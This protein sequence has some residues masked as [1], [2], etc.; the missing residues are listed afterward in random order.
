MA[1]PPGR[2]TRARPN[3]A[4]SGPS[5]NTEARIVLTSS[6]GA[7]G[8]G[9][10]DAS[11]S[12]VCPPRSA[13]RVIFAPMCK[14][15]RPIVRMSARSGTSRKTL[16][17][18][19]SRAAASCGSVAFFDP[20][21]ST[22]PFSGTPPSISIASIRKGPRRSSI[23]RFR[24]PAEN[25]AIE[26]GQVLDDADVREPRLCT[27]VPHGTGK[28][29]VDLDAEESTGD[30][31]ASRLG[32]DSPDHRQPSLRGE[33]RLGRLVHDDFGREAIS[34][35]FGNIRRI[36]DYTVVPR[37]LGERREEVAL[38]YARSSGRELVRVLS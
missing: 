7:S 29:R 25:V 2:E 13:S 22:S 14:R 34:F 27:E 15:S 16:R 12:S 10:S 1:H 17:P 9:R 30:E 8:L 6:Y 38:V 26:S 18:G 35:A 33:E 20:L 32:D 5:T 21:T 19:A 3:R 37:P 11:T 31:P 23:S 36:C 4:R 24:R 28:R